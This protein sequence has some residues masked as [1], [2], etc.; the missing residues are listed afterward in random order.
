MISHPS[1][2]P[3]V[4]VR[5]LE[6]VDEASC[7]LVVIVDGTSELSTHCSLHFDEVRYLTFDSLEFKDL[8]GRGVIDVKRISELIFNFHELA[9]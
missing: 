4:F 7:R 1:N 5:K 6:F 9:L 2:H 3:L 8:I